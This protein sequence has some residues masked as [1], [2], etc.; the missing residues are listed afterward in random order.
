MKRI[1]FSVIVFFLAPT[2][3]FAQDYPKFKVDLSLTAV[4]S[5][6][7]KI[8]SYIKRELRSLNDVEIDEENPSW[9]ISIV[10]QPIK[11]GQNSVGVAISTV[12]IESFESY[13]LNDFVIY[14]LRDHFDSVTSKFYILK[15]QYIQTGGEE[16]LKRMCEGIVA[17][18]DN[19]YLEPTR[20]FRREK[21]KLKKE[22]KS[23]KQ[24]N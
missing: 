2:F 9:V 12:I 18:F 13:G 23:K 14:E 17:D 15:N 11:V 21:K 19:D 3:A 7:T 10:A 22:L 8:S 1:I 16:H 24:Q 4:E 5:I 6:S 20:K